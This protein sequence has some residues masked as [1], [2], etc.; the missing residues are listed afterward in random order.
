M[1]TS[2]PVSLLRLLEPGPEGE[3]RVTEQT[4]RSFVLSFM[5]KQGTE[6]LHYNMN[7]CLTKADVDKHCEEFIYKFQDGKHMGVLG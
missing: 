6:A 1:A 4:Q 3:W 5:M 7:P 2:L